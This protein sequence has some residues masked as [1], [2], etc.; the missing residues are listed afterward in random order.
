MADF[1]C[2]LRDGSAKISD[3]AA[4]KLVQCEALALAQVVPELVL[5][6]HPHVR[7]FAARVLGFMDGM[8]ANATHMLKVLLTDSD[9][10]VA[11]AA[12]AALG[13]IAVAFSP[14]ASEH[15]GALVGPL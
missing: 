2:A 12:A 10:E 14:A 13:S 1:L 4:Q 7:A 11:C 6:E 5:D 3:T 15:V 9:S 8:A